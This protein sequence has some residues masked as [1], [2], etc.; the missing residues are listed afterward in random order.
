MSEEEVIEA[1]GRFAFSRKPL[2]PAAQDAR[3]QVE[4]FIMGEYKSLSDTMRSSL[5]WEIFYSDR[6]RDIHKKAV[7]SRVE[8][9]TM[10]KRA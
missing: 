6:L 4:N 5:K 8:Y 3:H 1:Y 2:T 10:P 7:A 9:P